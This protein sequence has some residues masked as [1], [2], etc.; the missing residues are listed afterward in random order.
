MARATSSLPVPRLAPEEHGGSSARI[1]C[2][3]PLATPIA[4]DNIQVVKI[5]VNDPVTGQLI[6][7][8][9]FDQCNAN[10]SVN[11]EVKFTEGSSETT[12]KELVLSEGAS[13][14]A[15]IPTLAKVKLEGG[16]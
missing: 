15:D 7:T 12:Q 16:S 5:T 3:P 14:E 13:A 1:A 11:S 10:S 8:K 9:T 2:Q 4:G 6:Q